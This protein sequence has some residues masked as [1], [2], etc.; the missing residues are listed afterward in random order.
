MSLDTTFL[1]D[2]RRGNPAAI[3]KAKSIEDSGEP[4]CVTAPVAVELLVGGHRFGGMHLDRTRK[5]LASLILLSTDVESCEEAGRIGADLLA[6]GEALGGTDLM[7]A[8]ISKRHG[9]PLLTRDRSFARVPG[10]AVETY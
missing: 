9:Q 10:L 5:L 1:I 7:I 4:R 6:R 3:A 8:G 2:L